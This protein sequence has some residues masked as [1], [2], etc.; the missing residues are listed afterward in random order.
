MIKEIKTEKFEGLAVL[1]PENASDLV[2]PK[3]GIV[4]L[5]FLLKN[6]QYESVIIP[7]NKNGY[8]IMGKATELTRQNC[9][10]IVKYIGLPWNAYKDYTNNSNWFNNPIQSFK[11]L[12]YSLGC[13]S[14][15][16]IPVPEPQGNGIDE[17][18]YCQTW[19]KDYE[20]AQGFTGTWLILKKLTN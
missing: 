9:A 8:E 2:Y 5:Y 18:D 4:D 7:Q 13:Y 1:V 12:L 10:D 20:E 19:I 3:I 15:N 6:G 16:P 17:M 11:S 14:E